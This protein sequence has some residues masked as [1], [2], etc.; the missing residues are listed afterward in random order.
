MHLLVSHSI[1]LIGMGEVKL[2]SS[3]CPVQCPPT[4]QYFVKYRHRAFDSALFN[5]PLCLF[6]HSALECFV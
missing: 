1:Y 2:S 5:Y 6:L 3:V 4:I